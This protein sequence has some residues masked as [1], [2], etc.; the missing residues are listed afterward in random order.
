[1]Q[2]Q[3]RLSLQKTARGFVNGT[4]GVIHKSTIPNHWYF[5]KVFV[6]EAA[7]SHDSLERNASY[8]APHLSSLGT[9]PE[10]LPI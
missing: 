1:M 6:A 2:V 5:L 4:S 9:N 7:Q 3:E 10:P 8:S